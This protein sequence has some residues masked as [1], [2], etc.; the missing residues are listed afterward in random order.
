MLT[1]QIYRYA[2]VEILYQILENQQIAHFFFFLNR[3]SKFFHNESGLHV[4]NW[5][6]KTETLGRPKQR[7]QSQSEETLGEMF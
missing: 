4:N 5:A 7:K 6:C 1:P 3:T 2:S